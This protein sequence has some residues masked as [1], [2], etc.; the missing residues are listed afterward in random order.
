MLPKAG[1]V[2][3]HGCRELRRARWWAHHENK[4]KEGKPVITSRCMKPLFEAPKTKGTLTAIE[5]PPYEHLLPAGQQ[6]RKGAIMLQRK[7]GYLSSLKASGWA[8]FK[9]YAPQG[10]EHP[11]SSSAN[12]I[13]Q[14]GFGFNCFSLEI[15]TQLRQIWL[16][17]IKWGGHTQIAGNHFTGGLPHQMMF[18]FANR[19]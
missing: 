7:S 11:I 16:A 10:K 4:I 17:V 2:S 3:N 8:N 14:N 13:N 15:S 5:L 6:R 19:Q 18:L 9:T 12:I 1:D